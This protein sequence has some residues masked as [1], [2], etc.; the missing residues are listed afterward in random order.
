MAGKPSSNGLFV[1]DQDQRFLDDV[2]A[3]ALDVI[4]CVEIILEASDEPDV[5]HPAAKAGR[6]ARSIQDKARDY[7][8]RVKQLRAEARTV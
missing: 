4:S 3:L 7:R 6:A 8:G 2:I 1:E 5:L